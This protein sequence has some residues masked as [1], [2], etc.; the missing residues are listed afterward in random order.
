VTF[1]FLRDNGPDGLVTQDAII[2]DSKSE[3][4]GLTDYS[5]MRGVEVCPFDTIL[6]SDF[7]D[8]EGV[9]IV[10]GI[11]EA[12]CMFDTATDTLTE[13]VPKQIGPGIVWSLHDY[14]TDLVDAIEI[15]G[16]PIGSRVAYTHVDQSL[17]TNETVESEDFLVLFEGSEA[18]IRSALDT[19]TITPVPQSDDEFHLK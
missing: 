17:T 15:S 5:C 9:G 18:D 14:S 19:L 8:R 2:S 10:R 1:Y 7:F 11:G 6:K 12:V 13:D 4:Y 16:F 3:P